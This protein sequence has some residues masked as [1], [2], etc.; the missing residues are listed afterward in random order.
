[1]P[2]FRVSCMLTSQLA[3]GDSPSSTIDV[4]LEKHLRDNIRITEEIQNLIESDS[5]NDLL[6]SLEILAALRDAHEPDPTSRA[7][8]VGKSQRERITKRKHTET[9]EDRDSIAAESPG[10]G[11]PSP[12]VSI[13]TSA[14][15]LIGK[16]ASRASSVPIAREA[17]VKAE[18][19][20]ES[21][22][23][24]KSKARL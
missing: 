12:K 17:S 8:S 15:R 13:S 1:M 9:I 5:G 2:S 10:P 22:D 6:K 14:S 21:A 23:S 16:V 20:G 18:D 11:G 3:R 19:G 24:L 7:G 4:E